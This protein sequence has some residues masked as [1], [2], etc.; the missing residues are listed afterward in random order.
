MRR[1]ANGQEEAQRVNEARSE[2]R[3][4]LN[5]HEGKLKAERPEQ[6]REEK[7]SSR[8]AEV[9]DTVEIKSM[10]VRA[11]VVGVNSDGSLELKAGIMNVKAK[12]SEVYLV[13]G[14]AAKKKVSYQIQSSS[15]RSA[16]SSEIDLRGMESIEA[17]NAA[18]MYIDNAVM[19]KLS[20]VTIIHGKGTGALRAAIHQMLKRNK[21]VKSF[22]LGRY[23]EGETG[24]T[25]VE[26][27]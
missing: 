24:V 8:N 23:G 20:T 19:A 7:K 3:R 9:G 22:R 27:K 26:L 15:V 21:A 18:E 4:K 12:Q 11:E 25:I 14:K 10:G 2:L 13:E 17:V 5:E 6:P 1:H 16:V